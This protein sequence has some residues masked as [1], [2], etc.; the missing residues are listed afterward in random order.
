[1][2]QAT[3]QTIVRVSIQDF[4]SVISDYNRYPEFV[5]GMTECTI[6]E[7]KKSGCKVKF[8]LDLMKKVDY[9]IQ[10]VEKPG[11]S[12]E[13]TLLESNLL[14]K[15]NGSWHLKALGGDETEVTYSL[16]VGFGLFVPGFIMDQL[17]KQ[18]LP[19]MLASFVDR[20]EVLFPPNGAGKK[21]RK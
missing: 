11:K 1:M 2:A 17:T 16:E 7:R 10:T 9:T 12:L 5:D 20:A 3:E 21:K 19:K 18:M 8:V 4:Y 6:L 13:W 14:R 15:N